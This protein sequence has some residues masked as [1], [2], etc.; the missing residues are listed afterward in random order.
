MACGLSDMFDIL[1]T[2]TFLTGGHAG[3]GRSRLSEEKFFQRCHAGVDQQKAGI[4]F[5]GDQGGAC[6]TGM[7]LA[8]KEG[9]VF[10]A[11]VI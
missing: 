11:Q 5:R 10:F 2:D 9:K 7:A 8:F 1:G 3:I 6:H 4:I